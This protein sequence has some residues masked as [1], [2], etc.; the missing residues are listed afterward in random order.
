MSIDLTRLSAASILLSCVMA[1][2][3]AA[4]A[5]EVTITNEQDADG[6][7]LTPLLSIFHDGTYDT[8]DA[9]GSASIGVETIAETGN[10]M[11]ESDAAML[12]GATTGVITSPGGF[13]GAP[14]IDP[15]ETASMTFD[16]DPNNDRFFSYLSMVIPSNDLF[17]GNENSM[18]YEVFDIAGAFTNLGA[19]QIFTTDIWDAGTEENNNLGAAFNAASGVETD[20]NDPITQQVSVFFLS[21]QSTAAETTLNLPQ[22]ATHL[23]TIELSQVPVPAAFPML[24]LGLGGLGFAARRRKG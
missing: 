17:I 23:A 16:L 6:L 1:S 21:G 14:V 9:G 8:F 12:A 10:A 4:A 11:P 7:F 24:L 13:P 22:D 5:I 18:A 2:A 3:A 19:I 20:T 15:G